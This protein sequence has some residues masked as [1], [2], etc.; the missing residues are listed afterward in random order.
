M[1]IQTHCGFNLRLT[2]QDTAVIAFPK[3]RVGLFKF[4]HTIE[5]ILAQGFPLLVL[6]GRQLGEIRA[7]DLEATVIAV[8]IK[9]HGNAD[10]EFMA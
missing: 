1:A 2:Y 10:G 3:W 6:F 8:G 5:E 9:R 4:L 7:C